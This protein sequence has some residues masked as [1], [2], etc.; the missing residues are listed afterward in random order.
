MLGPRINYSSDS[1]IDNPIDA[2]L[3]DHLYMMQSYY[4]SLSLD[5]KAKK[6]LKDAGV[7]ILRGF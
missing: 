1:D 3:F 2:W 4:Y 5:R 6:M 7:R